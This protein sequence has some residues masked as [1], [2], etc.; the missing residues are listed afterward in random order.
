M[1]VALDTFV[2]LSITTKTFFMKRTA[3]AALPITLLIIS[4]A[5]FSS[6]KKDKDEPVAISLQSLAGSYK[7][8]AWTYKYGT[9]PEEDMMQLLDACEKDDVITLKTDKTYTSADVGVICT[10][11]GDYTS[12]WDVPSATKIIVDGEEW[13]ID[14][15][16]GK[17]LK[18]SQSDT[19][20]GVTEVDKM[21]LTR[22]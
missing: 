16:D 1:G 11:P 4:L 5:T 18:I 2:S 15:Y 6:C 21:T 22:Q 13:A 10:P 12:D 17:V 14:S 9:M 3:F 8:T 7:L 20:G 19:S